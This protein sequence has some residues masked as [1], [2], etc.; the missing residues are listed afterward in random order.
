M[1][2]K[3]LII[4]VVT[5]GLYCERDDVPDCSNLSKILSKVPKRLTPAELL[6]LSS[7]N[8]NINTAT[9][10]KTATSIADQVKL[11]AEASRSIREVIPWDLMPP[12]V[13]ERGHKRLDKSHIILGNEIDW[14]SNVLTSDSTTG[15][16]QAWNFVEFPLTHCSYLV[17]RD[18]SLCKFLRHQEKHHQA[19]LQHVPPLVDFTAHSWFDFCLSLAY[20]VFNNRLWVHPYYCHQR[21]CSSGNGCGFLVADPLIDC[22]SDLPLRYDYLVE[23]WNDQLYQALS[24]TGILPDGRSQD[25]LRSCSQNGYGLFPLVP[26]LYGNI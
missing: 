9:I 13:A 24:K 22:D 26:V 21:I 2:S 3:E 19:A 23:D 11:A 8:S 14:F 16:V 6:A 25:I 10:S 5:S 17:F 1:Y 15:T 20:Y 4:Y 12:E 7:T 18:G